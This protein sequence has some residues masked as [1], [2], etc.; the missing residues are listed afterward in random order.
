MPLMLATRL[1]T[2]APLT[3]LED[4]ED[5]RLIDS[6]FSRPVVSVGLVRLVVTLVVSVP[7]RVTLAT[8]P[9][10]TTTVLVSVD[11][12]RRLFLGLALALLLPLLLGDPGLFGAPSF[13]YRMPRCGT[14]GTSDLFLIHLVPHALHSTGASG[15][16][17]LHCGD[18]K[19][20]MQ[21]GFVQ[22]P[23]GFDPLGFLGEDPSLLF[24]GLA[25]FFEVF[26][27]GDRDPIEPAA[28]AAY[29]CV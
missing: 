13:P 23:T 20:F 2:R 19:G 22:G 18:S 14:M 10:S 16:P 5:D 27:A 24:R 17:R 15:G 25:G 29:P 26:F 4:L 3:D 12:S 6:E 7:T 28:P 9:V 21:C 8:S 1:I 11:A